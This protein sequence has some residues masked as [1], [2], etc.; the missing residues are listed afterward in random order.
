MARA[1]IFYFLFCG[2]PWRVCCMRNPCKLTTKSFFYN[3]YISVSYSFK[4]KVSFWIGITYFW[5]CGKLWKVFAKNTIYYNI[6]IFNGNHIHIELFS[7]VKLNLPFHLMYAFDQVSEL[8]CNFYYTYQ[9]FCIEYNFLFLSASSPL[10]IILLCFISFLNF[11]LFG[12]GLLLL[13]PP[14][15]YAPACP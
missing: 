14:P 8:P 11:D 4:L 7:K 2:F 10:P 9:Y 5:G 6:Y 3:I 15:E 13:P 12:G 1:L